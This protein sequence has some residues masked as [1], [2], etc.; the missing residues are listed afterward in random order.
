MTYRAKK[1]AG[2]LAV[3][4]LLCGV[5]AVEAK[6]AKPGA[7]SVLDVR[8]AGTPILTL[9][10]AES[11][12]NLTIAN[13]AVATS[14]YTVINFQDGGPDGEF[15]GGNADF[16]NGSG[17]D[18]AILVSGCI[19]VSKAGDVT[20]GVTSDDGSRLSVNGIDVIIDDELHAARTT[21]GMV[22]LLKGSHQI[23]LLYFE[24]TGGATLELSVVSRGKFKLLKAAS[25][26]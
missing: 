26:P 22:P 20:F 9:D 23:E 14:D 1:F 12:T 11:L 16:P 21:I 17:D 19:S 8:S 25:C 7:F 15:L 5:A 2:S 4:A 6:A 13:S 3:A 24:R 18:F 10:E